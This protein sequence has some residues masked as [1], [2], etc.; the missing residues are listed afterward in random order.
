L[1]WG[2]PQVYFWQ[3]ATCIGGYSSAF[4]L[5]VLERDIFRFKTR[6]IP[7]GLTVATATVQLFYPISSPTDFQFVSTIGLVGT[8]SM[9]IAIITF[10]YLA[11]KSTGLMRKVC[12]ALTVGILVYAV[13]GMTM[14][15]NLL[16]ALDAAIPGIRTIVIVA[17]PIIKII[18][19]TIIAWGAVHFQL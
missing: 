8:L 15:E 13:A 12:V 10:I 3:A 6:L 9:L 7:T 11:V 1:L 17:V 16:S 18:A 2:K 5:F 14:S 4:L 19:F